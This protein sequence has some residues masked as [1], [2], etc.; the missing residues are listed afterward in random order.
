MLDVHHIEH[1]FP[2]KDE[3]PAYICID[4]A[5][6]VFKTAVTL[7]FWNEWKQTTRFIVD[8]YHYTN[9]KAT[10]ECNL[11][12]KDVSAPN[13]VGEKVDENENLIQYREFNT[14]VYE[15]L[16]AWLGGY[17]SILKQMTSKN[18]NWFIHSMLVYHVKH[19]LGRLSSSQNEDSIDDESSEEEKS[20]ASSNSSQSSS[21]TTQSDENSD[22]TDSS[23][24][25]MHVSD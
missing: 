4:K 12:P 10:D 1:L 17:E 18:F 2:N 23:D 9:H 20:S 6:Q 5:C 11:A 8:S 13:L 3:R 21:Q 16:N 15:Q 14:Q 24:D 7:K 25:E 19:V 22:S